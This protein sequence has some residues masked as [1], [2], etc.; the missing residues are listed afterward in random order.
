MSWI[1]QEK[2]FLWK[3]DKSKEFKIPYE[4]GDK[5]F[6]K[7]KWGVGTRPCPFEGWYDGIEY[8][9]DEELF[10]HKIDHD[11][12]PEFEDVESFIGNGWKSAHSMPQWASRI[13]LEITDIRV[14]RLRDVGYH[15]ADAEG[16]FDRKF[17]FNYLE[18]GKNKINDF[19]ELWN[20]IHKNKPEKS[21]E[22]NPFVW[23]LT[24]KKI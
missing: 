19:K 12:L 17:S 2:E 11:N 18:L 10:C 23:V 8:E 9:A 16:I 20:S 4:I 13:T 1:I 6:V 5:I 3:S 7:E 14:E 15:E 22:S 24:F 21:W